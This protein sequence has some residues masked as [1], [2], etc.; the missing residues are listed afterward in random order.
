MYTTLIG[1]FSSLDTMITTHFT[2]YTFTYYTINVMSVVKHQSTT[3]SKLV[4]ILKK[5]KKR[6][7]DDLYLK[8]Y[9]HPQSNFFPQL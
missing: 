8:L 3:F 9:H 6:L 2:I 4:Q 7:K 1:D 5:T